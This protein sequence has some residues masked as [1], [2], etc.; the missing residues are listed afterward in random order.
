MALFEKSEETQERRAQH[1]TEGALLKVA[2]SNWKWD[3]TS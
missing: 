2:V 1:T 3:S